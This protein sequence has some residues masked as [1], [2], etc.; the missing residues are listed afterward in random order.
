MNF[1]ICT[2]YLALLG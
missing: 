2:V 1:V